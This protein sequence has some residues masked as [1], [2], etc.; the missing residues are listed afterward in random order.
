MKTYR[1]LLGKEV[2]I[3]THSGAHIIARLLGYSRLEL[4][5]RQRGVCY[6]SHI[7]WEDVCYIY[8]CRQCKRCGREFFTTLDTDYCH[9]CRE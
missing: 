1:Q 7:P 6:T 8:E 4:K 5:I 2:M 3:V 9:L